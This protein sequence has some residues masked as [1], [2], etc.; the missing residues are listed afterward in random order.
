MKCESVVDT[1]INDK[2][3]L[4]TNWENRPQWYNNLCVFTWHIHLY[5]T[6]KA[7]GANGLVAMD[8]NQG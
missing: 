5:V 7:S 2:Q 8:I 3:I 6:Y 1:A 4:L